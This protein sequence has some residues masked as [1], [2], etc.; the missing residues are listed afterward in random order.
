MNEASIPSSTGKTYNASPP[1]PKNSDSWSNRLRS[2]LCLSTPQAPALPEQFTSCERLNSA[3]VAPVAHLLRMKLTSYRLKDRVHIQDMDNA[4]LITPQLE[5]QLP[6]VLRLR[7][8][9]IRRTE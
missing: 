8:E 2:N 4:G 3:W 1:P 7:L 5:A 9:E 6:E